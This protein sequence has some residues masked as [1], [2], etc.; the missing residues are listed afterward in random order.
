M[1]N[2]AVEIETLKHPQRMLISFFK[3][4]NGTVITPLFI[5]KLQLGLQCAQIFRF[6]QYSHQKCFKNFFRLLVDVRREGGENFLQG[7]EAK[8]MKLLGNS[9]YGNQ[10]MYSSRHTI[11]KYLNNEKTHKAVSEPVVQSLQT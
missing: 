3:L 10:M 7:V 9:F 11:M 8:S 2:F 4:E 1:K 6:V 5:F